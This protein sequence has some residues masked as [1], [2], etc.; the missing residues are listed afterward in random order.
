[1]NQS[2]KAARLKAL[3]E[4]N[5]LFVIPNPW[6]AGTAKLFEDHGK[7]SKASRL[8][9]RSELQPA[10]LRHVLPDG[11]KCGSVGGA[12]DRLLGRPSVGEHAAGAVAAAPRRVP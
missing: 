3:H 1:M 11:A 10:L 7:V 8:R 2:E 9:T 5:E 4:G 12:G 6:D